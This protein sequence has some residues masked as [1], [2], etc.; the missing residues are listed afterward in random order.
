MA[1]S[2]G[3]APIVNVKNVN[4]ADYLPEPHDDDIS[5]AGEN[6]LEDTIVIRLRT[7]IICVKVVAR[8]FVSQQ[9]KK[10]YT[11]GLVRKVYEGAAVNTKDGQPRYQFH[12][13]VTDPE[14]MQ[15]F[16]ELRAEVMKYIDRHSKRIAGRVDT[17]NKNHPKRGNLPMVRA[18]YMGLPEH[19][20]NTCQKTENAPGGVT[21]PPKPPTPGFPE[22]RT[23][24]WDIVTKDANFWLKNKKIT[25]EQ[26]VAPDTKFNDG[27]F[28]LTF[29]VYGIRITANKVNVAIKVT[30]VFY[31]GERTQ[32]NQ[33]DYA[34]FAQQ[35]AD[36]SAGGAGLTLAAPPSSASGGTKRKREED[37]AAEA[38]DRAALQEDFDVEEDGAG[39]AGGE[40]EEVGDERPA[41]RS[42]VD[43]AFEE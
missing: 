3:P 41:K 12:A 2:S 5:S 25:L 27:L 40:A 17:M 39:G 38:A 35:F 13:D 37:E 33:A 1:A 16:D 18:N 11:R 6:K 36:A 8:T 28:T 19:Y 21:W 20:T 9:T 43:A 31:T 42:R 4:W 23:I 22:T 30:G 29:R 10:Q 34:A 14:E 7:P 15:K 32:S 26:A 24:S